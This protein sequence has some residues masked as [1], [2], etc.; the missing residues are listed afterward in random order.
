[1][2]IYIISNKTLPPFLLPRR[3]KIT[4]M[5]YD[6]L[7]SAQLLTNSLNMDPK[8]T[9]HVLLEIGDQNN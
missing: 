9:K 1:M 4:I 8:P 5:R 6:V 2:F 7:S 3:Y